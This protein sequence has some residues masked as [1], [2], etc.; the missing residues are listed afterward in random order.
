MQFVDETLIKMKILFKH[1][2]ET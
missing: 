1:K 2:Y